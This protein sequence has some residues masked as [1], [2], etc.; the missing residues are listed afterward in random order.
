MREAADATPLAA[1]TRYSGVYFAPRRQSDRI[2]LAMSAFGTKQTW[3][4]A[5]HMSAF[6]GKADI[7]RTGRHVRL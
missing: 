2:K 3:V 7:A 4:S 6:V 1:A 5:L